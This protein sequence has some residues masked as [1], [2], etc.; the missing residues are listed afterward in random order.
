MI[1][2]SGLS[3]DEIFSKK[4]RAV[5]I[6]FAR[7]VDLDQNTLNAKYIQDT[8]YESAALHIAQFC[9]GFG[10]S[11]R[12]VMLNLTKGALQAKRV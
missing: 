12:A 4:C 3:D 10:S 7:T 8:V 2:E 6:Y 9:A 11:H 1:F 5:E